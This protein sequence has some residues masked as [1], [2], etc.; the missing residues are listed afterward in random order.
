[1]DSVN[2]AGGNSSGSALYGSTQPTSPAPKS[3][4]NLEDTVHLLNQAQDTVDQGG[5][6]D[7]KVPLNAL[8]MAVMVQKTSIIELQLRDSVTGMQE[9]HSELKNAN[10][11]IAEARALKAASSKAENEEGTSYLSDKI[12]TFMEEKN[13]SW[14]VDKDRNLTKKDWDVVIENVKGWSESLTSTSQLEMTKLQS[15]SGK[16]NQGVEMLSQFVAKYFRGGD[17]IIKNL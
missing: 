11:I 13:I 7:F 1:M 8:M 2:G 10:D 4:A 9:N 5:E 3:S 16:L 12:L 17:S 6:Y 14:N 15:L